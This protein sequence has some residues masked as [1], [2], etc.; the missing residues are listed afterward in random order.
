M[1]L[2]FALLVI[3]FAALVVIVTFFSH[4][5]MQITQFPRLIFYIAVGL[6]IGPLGFNFLN[7]TLFAVLDPDGQILR[8]I[9]GVAVAIIVFEGGYSF[10]RC[11][12]HEQACSPIEFRTL[13][14]NVLRLSLI[15]GFLTAALMTLVFLFLAGISVPFALL[16][17]ALTMITG[18]TVINPCVRRLGIKEEVAFTLEGEGLINDALGVIVASGI[19]SAILASISGSPFALPV[20]VAF[21]LTVGIF[22]G[23]G[24]GVMGVFVSQWLGPRFLKRFQDRCDQPGLEHLSRIGMIVAAF[25]AY[26][27]A[28]FF[29][30]ETG[31]I[32]SL[33]AGILI[34]N[35]D[36]LGFKHPANWHETTFAEMD[37]KHHI[38][39]GVHAF[40]SD[41]AQL[42][43]A[44]IFLLLTAF[45]TWDLLL[46]TLFTPFFMA[47]L[48]VVIL[49]MLVIRPLAVMVSTIKTKFH[50]RE[51]LFMS[52]FGPRGI[53]IAAT[54]VFIAIT[55]DVGYGL[56]L[57]QIPGYIF[58]IVLI[59]VIIQAGLA[60]YTAKA[61]KI[62]TVQYTAP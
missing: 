14:R 16:M 24:V 61:C 60:P 37:L 35:R 42:A 19:F 22:V 13:I 29:A 8:A 11:M 50:L 15:G 54:G 31:I 27:V 6:L 53:V 26:A 59:T 1:V 34:G 2:E 43:I 7:P 39:K 36:R 17:G 57:P 56:S 5:F 44:T 38:E 33:I 62:C 10:N 25:S 41:L 48:V 55:L 20:V 23:I 49:L 46:V 4:L 28:E 45:L 18:P 40:Q 47:G 3:I 52:F 12:P 30:H 51:R 9:I 58:L 32:A 21:N